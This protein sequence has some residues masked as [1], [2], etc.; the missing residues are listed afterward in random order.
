[1]VSDGRG[2]LV[3]RGGTE[4]ERSLGELVE[5]SWEFVGIAKLGRE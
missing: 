2:V 3:G 5:V 4:V 1:M